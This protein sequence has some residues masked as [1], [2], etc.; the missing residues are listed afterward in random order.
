MNYLVRLPHS[1]F[2]GSLK[3]KVCPRYLLLGAPILL[4]RALFPCFKASFLFL[5]LIWPSFVCSWYFLNGCSNLVVIRL[6]IMIFSTWRTPQIS[7]SPLRRVPL[8]VTLVYLIA[9]TIIFGMNIDVEHDFSQKKGKLGTRSIPIVN[10]FLLVYLSI[11]LGK[12]LW[13]FWHFFLV[14][15]P[16]LKVSLFLWGFIILFTTSPLFLLWP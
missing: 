12:G 10:E 14:L 3:V 2:C 16:W 4:V 15:I 7:W 8:W 5:S 1:L 11:V 9:M 6:E 13:N